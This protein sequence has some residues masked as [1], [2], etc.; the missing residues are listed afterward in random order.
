MVKPLI[1]VVIP[2]YNSGNL[3][4][5]TVDSLRRQTF[6]LFEV[7]IIND[8]SDEASRDFIVEYI[9]NANDL[10]IKLLDQENKGI[11]AARNAGIMASKGSYIAFLDDDDI[12]YPQKLERCYEI[13]KRNGSIDLVCHNEALKSA[14]G[15]PLKVF[16]YGPQSPEMF[17]KLLFK[18]NCLSTSAVVVKKDILLEAG[19]F[20]ESPLFFSVEDFDLWL[21]LAKKYKF[22][23][24]NEILGEYIIDNNNVS[25]RLERHF[26]NLI[27]ALAVNFREYEKK[28]K[29]DF[30][31]INL[32]ISRAYLAMFKNFALNRKFA[33]AANYFIKSIRQ[34]FQYG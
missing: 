27:Q 31:L 1:S 12:W 11:A 8:G 6:R 33:K 23:F 14:S 18:G 9:A 13:F 5:N 28:K 22:Y 16:R 30:L 2:T 15:K 3:I 21:R 10:D 29:L 19:L 26:N 7:M 4:L 20:R 32:R 17:R 25:L 24:L 34:F